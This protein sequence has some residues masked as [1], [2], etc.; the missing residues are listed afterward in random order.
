MTAPLVDHVT[1]DVIAASHVND[2]ADYIEKG[3][4]RINT[5]AIYVGAVA[6]IDSSGNIIPN[7]IRCQDANGLKIYAADGVTLLMS[8]DVNGNLGIRGMVYS[9]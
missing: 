3:T 8:L 9:L 5:L 4:Y 1:G 6:R 2:V 7:S